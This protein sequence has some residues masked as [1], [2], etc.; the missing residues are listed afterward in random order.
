MFNRRGMRPSKRRGGSGRVAVLVVSLLAAA[1]ASGGPLV[2]FEQVALATAQGAQFTTV[3]LGPDGKLY[4]TA[5]D[6]EI[7]RWALNADGTTGAV[8]IIASLQTAEGGDRLLIGM[9]F[10]PASTA[11]NLVA[12]VSHTTFGFADMPD[13]GGKITRLSGPDLE[14]VE[15]FL[16]GLPRSSKDHVTNGIDFGPDAALYFV[17]GSTSAMGA[18]DRA[19]SNRPERLLTGA[20]LR[21]DPSLI[22]APPLDVQTEEGGNYDP[23]APGAPL[24]VY[25][26][27]TRNAYDLLWHR[28]GQL[29]VPTNGS[30]SGGN[31]PAGVIGAACGD[32]S[33][34]AGPAVGGLADVGTQADYLF[35]V[36][37]GGYYGHPNPLRCEY[38]MNGGNPTSGPDPAE[39]VEY[40]TG[41]GPDVN[42]RGFAFDFGDH[43]SPNGIIEYK[44]CLFDG[45]LEAKLLV[46]RY[47]QGDDIIVLTPGGAKLDIVGAQT[48]ITGFTGF[49]NPLDLTQN[50]ANGYLYVSEYGGS[51]ITL[52]RPLGA[53]DCPA[54]INGDGVVNVLDLIDLLLSFGQPAVL[55][56]PSPDV[57]RDGAVNVLDLTDLLPEFGQPCP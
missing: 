8:Q 27:G 17:Q 45:A 3:T 38:V 18:P 19:W 12:W 24:T 49:N 26:S 53:A 57:N 9:A 50:P 7:R 33:T 29:Y 41:T 15:D 51:K 34:Y 42:Y 30:A 52:L 35:R 14:T 39:V 2:E 56:C 55:G 32:G 37:P 10:D 40:P 47:S 48:G 4:A 13:W 23:Y 6:G 43:R 46:V 28:N 1:G 54:D 5:I 31:T 22:T 25:A 36:E 21:L 44:S 20:V 16:I 11:Q